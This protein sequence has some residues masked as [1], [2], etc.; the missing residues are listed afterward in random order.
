MS[1]LTLMETRKSV[2]EFAVIGD[3]VEHSLSPILHNEVFRQI[4]LNANYTKQFVGKNNLDD[5]IIKLKN[6]KFNGINITIPHK[7]NIINKC[8]NLN[9]RAGEIGAINCVSYK[10][11][12]LWGFN[13]DW[14]GFTMLLKANNIDVLGKSILIIGAG[15]VAYSILYSLLKANAEIIYINNRTNE[16]TKKLILNFDLIK[17]NS[18]IEELNNIG[19]KNKKI[20][21]IINCTPLGM[22][23]YLNNS[24]ISAEL[25]LPT[26]IIIDTIY[27]PLKTQL[28]IDSEQR[29]AKIING[30]DMFIYQGLS[31]IDIWYGEDIS[32]KVNYN[33]I[34]EKLIEQLC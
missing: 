6:G 32:K 26:H 20:D 17:Y 21:V 12:K 16:N 28:L 22:V 19:L 3:P 9:P 30:L 4:N 23:P 14:F 1:N 10:N 8:D 24:P 7:T 18:K 5:F 2:K 15:G 33:L 25:I 29:G 13:T 27:T 11:N 31:S 34:K